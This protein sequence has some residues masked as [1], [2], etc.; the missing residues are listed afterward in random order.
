LE[1]GGLPLT[2]IETFL[3]LA[4]KYEFQTL[5]KEAS[6][7]L[8]H[9][10]P[11]TL[12]E[13][14]AVH[15]KYTVIKVF[16]YEHFDFVRLARDNMLSRILPAA[17]YNCCENMDFD[18]IFGGIVRRDG[19]LSLLS[20]EDQQLCIKA[21]RKLIGKQ[22]EVFGWTGSTSSLFN[23]GCNKTSKCKEARAGLRTTILGPHLKCVAI[24][25]WKASWE[26]GCCRT[27]INKAKQH[28]N[29]NRQKLWQELP[30]IF[31]LPSWDELL[32]DSET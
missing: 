5:F 24:S 21:W 29:T 28:H 22:A 30:Q 2:D 7:R 32:K 6:M 3:R 16:G 1:K 8:E 14:D 23:N 20:A 25:P 31:N 27:C 17:L 19:T 18:E 4:R 26:R 10:F 15:G 11:S 12:A 9:E 13:W